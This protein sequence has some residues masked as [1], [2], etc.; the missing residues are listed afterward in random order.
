MTK[1][2]QRVYDV[3]V[4]DGLRFQYTTYCDSVEDAKEFVKKLNEDTG[5][6]HVLM[7]K[8]ND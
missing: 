1:T 8:M 7:E 2:K 6:K 5:I 4:R 3:Y